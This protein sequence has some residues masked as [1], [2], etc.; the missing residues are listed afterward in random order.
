[1][2]MDH[3]ETLSCSYYAKIDK[4]IEEVFD[5]VFSGSKINGYF[6]TG[7]KPAD[8]VEGTTVYW[9]FHDHPEF[10][11]FPVKVVK[12]EKDKLIHLQWGSG[13]EDGWNDVKIE[14]ER[15]ESNANQTL[16]RVTESGWPN[17]P[18]GVK[19]CSGNC[20]GWSNMLACLKVY[21]EYG[22]NL[23]EFMF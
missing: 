4:P 7:S 3:T 5:A 6:A 13:I 19:N 18:E 16:V 10:P 23:R 12:T 1:M 15:L 9:S 22:K 21:V 8:L 17:T 11:P 2:G 20:G 14:F